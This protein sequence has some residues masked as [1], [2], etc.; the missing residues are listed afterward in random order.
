M[1]IRIAQK[2]VNKHSE[3]KEMEIS[4]SEELKKC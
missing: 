3:G 4:T 2:L 1:G